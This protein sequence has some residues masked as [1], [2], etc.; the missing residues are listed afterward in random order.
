MGVIIQ[1]VML[2]FVK[3]FSLNVK[4]NSM[5]TFMNNGMLGLIYTHSYE[6]K[7]KKKK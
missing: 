5:N 1:T 4:K 6:K 2:W 3:R 7:E